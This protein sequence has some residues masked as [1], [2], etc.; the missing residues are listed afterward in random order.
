MLEATSMKG[1]EAISENL[2]WACLQQIQ[3]VNEKFIKE[4]FIVEY[5]DVLEERL[6]AIFEKSK[7]GIDNVALSV[8][9]DA[10]RVT[11]PQQLSTSYKS[12][13]G[14]TKPNHFISV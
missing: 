3:K 1:F 5:D 14:G 6:H 11:E 9:I 12:F 13:I 2:M 8:F 4:A 10:T 7:N